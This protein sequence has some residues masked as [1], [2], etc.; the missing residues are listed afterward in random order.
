MRIVTVRIRATA[1][2]G[3]LLERMLRLALP[4]LASC[5]VAELGTPPRADVSHLVYLDS[6]LPYGCTVFPGEDD[7][8]QWLSS[9]VPRPAVL[10]A[11]S[12][13][14]DRWMQLADCVTRI[15]APFD[16]QFTDLDPGNAPHVTLVVGGAPSDLALPSSAGGAA[17]L[18]CPDQVHDNGMAFVFSAP[19]GDVDE[20]C[21]A[22]AQELGHVF[23][24]DHELDRNDPMSWIGLPGDKRGGF[25]DEEVTCGEF[26]PRWCK[27]GREYQNSHRTLLDVV[28]PAL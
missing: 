27:C 4:F 7:A 8:P 17:P 9:I 13:G 15:Y 12:W 28:G 24:L 6:C 19:H 26:E 2:T 3:A 1:T 23:G 10:S 11:F 20:L 21:W 25:Q 5:A 18:V 14:D 22:A 16:L